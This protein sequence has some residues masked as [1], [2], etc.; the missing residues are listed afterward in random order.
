MQIKPISDKPLC[1]GHVDLLIC[2]AGFES[3]SKTLIDHIDMSFV[4]KV[5][6]LTYPHPSDSA[7]MNREHMLTRVSGDNLLSEEL[8]SDDPLENGDLFTRLFDGLKGNS[9]VIIDISTMTREN[10]MIML[11]VAKR[12][13]N[14]NIL[15]SYTPSER[16]A[17]APDLRRDDLKNYWIS[18]GVGEIRTVLGYA[19]ESS[20]LKQ[21]ALI[22]LSGFELERAQTVID[23]FEPDY[24]IVGKAGRTESVTAESCVINEIIFDELCNYNKVDDVFDF[25][26]KAINVTKKAILNVVEKYHEKANIVICPM[27]TKPSTLAVASL[28]LEDPSIQVCYAVATDYN[29]ALYSR[30]FEKSSVF[31]YRIDEI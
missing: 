9:H 4:K 25:S 13:T 15:F 12:V 24:L 1:I 8:L 5:I 22:I 2:C 27:N 16:Y 7:Q 18:R 20:P 31:L 29:S 28:A 14:P 23:S 19:G 17:I 6:L 21:L 11:K 30:E 10:L 26:C 3:R